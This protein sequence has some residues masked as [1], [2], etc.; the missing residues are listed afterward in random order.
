MRTTFVDDNHVSTVTDG[1]VLC[2]TW[3]GDVIL[4]R[5]IA[6]IDHQWMLGIRKSFW[7]L[8]RARTH[9]LSAT[10]IQ[11][12]AMHIKMCRPEGFM[13]GADAFLVS[14]APCSIPIV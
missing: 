13:P 9:T 8:T 11:S 3:A 7:D 4:E 1:D 2:V 14:T 12:I 10:D 5:V 6:V